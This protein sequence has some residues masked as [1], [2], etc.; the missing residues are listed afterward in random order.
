MLANSCACL[1]RT[2]QPFAHPK[3][4]LLFDQIVNS[5]K[6]SVQVHLSLIRRPGEKGFEP[7]T[8]GFGNHYSTVKTTL[9]HF[10]PFL[11]QPRP[12][13]LVVLAK[14]ARHVVPWHAIPNCGIRNSLAHP[15][16][17]ILLANS[18]CENSTVV[19]AKIGTC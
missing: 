8:F 9:L 16:L 14:H 10:L 7:L 5:F 4:T 19:G 12:W 18:A 17:R 2:T 6:S 15:E 1:L 13:E 11:K 3:G